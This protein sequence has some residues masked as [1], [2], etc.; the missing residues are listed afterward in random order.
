[1]PETIG[2]TMRSNQLIV[3]QNH[4]SIKGSLLVQLGDE[5]PRLEEFEK[6]GVSKQVFKT[7]S[8]LSMCLVTLVTGP[9]KFRRDLETLEA[10]EAINHNQTGIYD[11]S[12]DTD[13]EIIFSGNT[14]FVLSPEITDGPYYVRGESIRQDVTEGQEGIPL[15]LEV[16]Y[17]DVTTCLPI[18]ELYVDHWSC[19]ATGVYA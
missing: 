15:Y 1:M 17:L 4:S 5:L 14:S 19:N 10:F 9:R 3:A 8:A 18:P 16:Q 2:L 12:P 11:Y 13:E 7:S 6:K